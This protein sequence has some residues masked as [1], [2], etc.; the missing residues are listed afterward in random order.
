MR[1]PIFCLLLILASCSAPDDAPRQ[2]EERA[3][4]PGVD[5][6][7]AP[8]VAFTYDYDFRLPARRIAAAQ[9]VHAQACERLGVGRCRITGMRYALNGSHTVDA[10]LAFKLDPTLARAFG[11]QGIATIESAEGMLVRAQIGGV[12]AGA[13]MGRLDRDRRRAE[14]ERTRIERDLARPGLGS[15]ARAE[16]MRQRTELDQ[17]T[18]DIARDAEGQQ[19]SLAGTPVTFRYVSGQAIRGFDAASPLTGAADTL[20]ASA[21]WTLSVV[22]GAIALLGPPGLVLALAWLTWR[23]IRRRWP[24][25]RSAA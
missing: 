15:A 24:G 16:L 8:G 13:A 19:E 14:E 23:A 9:E 25:G 21:Q 18:R 1:A 7:A 6:T 5:V 2:K 22:L 3:A 4:A 20:L 10:M 17:R 12:D 11:K